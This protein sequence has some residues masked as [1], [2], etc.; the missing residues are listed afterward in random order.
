MG[1]AKKKLALAIRVPLSLAVRALGATSQC[2]SV[3]RIFERHPPTSEAALFSDC[4][5]IVGGRCFGVLLALS[6]LPTL[7]RVKLGFYLEK[8]SNK[9][10]FTPLIN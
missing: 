4:F 2:R 10:K 5:F 8:N 9:L 3:R 7:R 1:P 6:H